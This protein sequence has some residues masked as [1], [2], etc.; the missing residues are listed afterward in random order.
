MTKK[1]AKCN[2]QLSEQG[3]HV[4]LVSWTC[5]DASQLFGNK[6][7]TWIAAQICRTMIAALSYS[8]MPSNRTDLVLVTGHFEGRIG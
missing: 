8:E 6:H 1:Y 5:V 2:F 3:K 7:V 4:A